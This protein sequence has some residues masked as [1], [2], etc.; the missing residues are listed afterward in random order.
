MGLWREGCSEREGLK[1]RAAVFRQ[2]KN[3]KPDPL[4]ARPN[5]ELIYIDNTGK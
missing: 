1:W 4:G 5:I 3:G 2:Y